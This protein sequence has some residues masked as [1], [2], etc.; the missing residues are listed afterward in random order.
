MPSKQNNSLV[1]TVDS[2][3]LSGPRQGSWRPSGTT[4][5]SFNIDSTLPQIWLP[6]EACIAFEEAFGIVWH[7]TARLYLLDDTAHAKLLASNPAVNFNIRE[8]SDRSV[9]YTLP[10][11]A[12]DLTATAP[13]VSGNSSHYFPLRRA[14]SPEEYVLGRT[15]LQEIYISVD[16]DRAHFNISQAFPGGG[17]S[18]VIPILPPNSTYSTVPRDSDP[19]DSRNRSLSTEASIGIGIGTA[20]AL[21]MIFGVFLAW[22]KR[23]GVFHKQPQYEPEGSEKAEMHGESK[24]WIEVMSSERS[25]LETQENI[26]E[27][28]GAVEVVEL[29]GDNVFHEL[30]VGHTD[31]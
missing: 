18:R 2:I 15:F 10:Y 25:E 30:E 9:T 21:L 13:L 17:S 11:T 12:F 24:P 29:Q 4:G 31:R 22:R 20:G 23:W 8:S 7:D 19:I 27:V 1:V 5:A 14:S 28:D 3:T 16:Y 26:K 6:L